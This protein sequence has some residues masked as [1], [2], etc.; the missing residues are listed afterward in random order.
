MQRFS[1]DGYASIERRGGPDALLPSE[2]AH[3]EETLTLKMLSDDLLYYG[4]ERAPFLLQPI[5][6]DDHREARGF[7]SAGRGLALVHQE[8]EG[9]GRLVPGLRASSGPRQTLADG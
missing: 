9:L 4:R 5:A 7:D 3:D 8:L 1:I 2:L 6:I